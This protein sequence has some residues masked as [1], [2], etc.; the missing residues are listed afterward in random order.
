MLNSAA[1][2]KAAL[3][4]QFSDKQIMLSGNQIRGA[5]PTGPAE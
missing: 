2:M 5:R 4:E 1:A 3:A